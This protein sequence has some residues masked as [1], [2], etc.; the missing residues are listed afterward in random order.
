VP[1][2]IL[3]DLCERTEDLIDKEL[4]FRHF[5][6]LVREASATKISASAFRSKSKKAKRLAVSTISIRQAL[7]C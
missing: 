6:R 3:N 1:R 7:I 5:R 2:A 4:R